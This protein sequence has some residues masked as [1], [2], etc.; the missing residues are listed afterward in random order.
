MAFNKHTHHEKFSGGSNYHS[1][2]SLPPFNPHAQVYTPYSPHVQ[3]SSRSPGIDYVPLRTVHTPSRRFYSTPS[4]GSSGI[5]LLVGMI[6]VP[7]ILVALF[8]KLTLGGMGYTA[9]SMAATGASAASAS[10]AMA[11]GAAT[12]GIGALALYGALGFAYLYSSAKECY[13]SDKNVFA[14]IKSRV[15]NEEG[16]TAKGVLKSIGAVLWSPFLLL[17]G[18]AGM[19]VKAVENARSAKSPVQKTVDTPSELTA[20]PYTKLTEEPKKENSKPLGQEP[21]HYPSV[22]ATEQEELGN[23][24]ESQT[25]TSSSIYPKIGFGN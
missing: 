11:L 2:Q 18:L 19:G 1:H 4:S 13:R 6:L 23:L 24:L 17:G 16:F 20:F 25:L 22:L 5:Y 12:F 8:L 21:I 7:V 10:G 15:V 9:A 14:M 3:V